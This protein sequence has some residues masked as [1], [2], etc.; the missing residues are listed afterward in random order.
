MCII[1]FSDIMMFSALKFCILSC[2]K[3][4]SSGI[5]GGDMRKTAFEGLISAFVIHFLESIICKLATGD[6]S[7]F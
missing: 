4:R 7:M 3:N 5:M 1:V 6:I 2:H